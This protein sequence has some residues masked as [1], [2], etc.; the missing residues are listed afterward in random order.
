MK[1]LK[2]KKG[3]MTF[4]KGF[5]DNENIDV[6]K[7]LFSN[8]YPIAIDNNMLRMNGTVKFY[9]YSE[10]FED[11]KEGFEAPE[12]LANITSDDNGKPIKITFEKC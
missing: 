8:F 11:S 1:N 3:C 6:I 12:Y 7:L 9:G 4:T 5:L 2:Q 10:H